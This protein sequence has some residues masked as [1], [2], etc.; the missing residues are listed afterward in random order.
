MARLSL[1]V[2][3]RRDARFC[4]T[5]ARAGRRGE[6]KQ[7]RPAF[8]GNGLSPVVLLAGNPL[9]GGH[10]LRPSRG[11][12]SQTASAVM[13]LVMGCSFTSSIS[14][15]LKVERAL[16]S[17]LLGLS[18]TFARLADLLAAELQD[19]FG[20]IGLLSRNAPFTPLGSTFYRFNLTVLKSN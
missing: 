9:V 13:R 2:R 11:R 14:N 20:W 17:L 10:A 16:C 8:L 19:G 3:I 18:L 4:R 12:N 5:K 7:H 1:P 15:G 6:V